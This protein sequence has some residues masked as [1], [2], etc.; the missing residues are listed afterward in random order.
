MSTA[1]IQRV[2]VITLQQG[3]IMTFSNEDHEVP[4]DF[5]ADL[6]FLGDSPR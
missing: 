2:A 1:P 6:V 5:L 3:D 4:R